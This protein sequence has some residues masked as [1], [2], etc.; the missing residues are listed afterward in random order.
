M[1]PCS[2]W[3]TLC[4]HNLPIKEL[5]W[6]HVAGTGA[7]IPFSAGFRGTF[8]ALFLGQHAQ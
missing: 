1:L 7:H 2:S 8:L 4:I 5:I 6:T 3:L